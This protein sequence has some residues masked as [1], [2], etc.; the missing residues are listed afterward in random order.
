MEPTVVG[1]VHADE[2]VRR[3]ISERLEGEQG[4]LLAAVA[5]RCSELR[6]PEGGSRVL[7]AGGAALDD[8]DLAHATAPLVVAASGRLSEARVALALGAADLVGW[9]RDADELPGA[10]RRAAAARGSASTEAAGRVVAVV[11]ARGGLGTTTFAAWLAGA[12]DA[13]ALV[14]LDPAGTLRSFGQGGEPMLAAL[15]AGTGAEHARSLLR[16]V[17]IAT[18]VCFGEPSMRD[19]EPVAIRALLGT[20][21]ALGGWSVIDAGR[22]DQGRAAAVRG[23]DARILLACDEVAAVRAV[24]ARRFG[25]TPWVLRPTAARSQIA[26]RDLAEALGSAPLATI[27]TDPSV[28]KAAN[29][30]RLAPAPA[31]VP[32]VAASLTGAPV[33]R[34]AVRRG[35]PAM[36]ARLRT[37]FGAL[38]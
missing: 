19:P 24:E 22:G 4:I 2:R 35:V 26:S 30:G 37:A 21:R 12:L 3:A 20:L 11:G 5:S 18:P 13:R 23:A 29:L 17:G 9:P 15:L 31:V 27:P 1:I 34:L 8:P 25:G 14:E 38:R 7:V 16:D 33:V 6:L 10:I 36:V 32:N 28:V